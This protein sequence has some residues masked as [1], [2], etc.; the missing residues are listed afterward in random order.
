[1]T[2]QS[3][4]KTEGLCF[5]SNLTLELLIRNTHMGS[6]VHTCAVLNDQQL[7]R[8]VLHVKGLRNCLRHIAVPDQV[9]KKNIDRLHLLRLPGPL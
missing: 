8:L 1:M 6:V 3:R 5:G 7:R 9:Y 4:R 2:R